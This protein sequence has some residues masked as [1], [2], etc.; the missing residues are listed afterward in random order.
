MSVGNEDMFLRELISDVCRLY[1]IYPYERVGREYINHIDTTRSD[2]IP[3]YQPPRIIF[4]QYMI[5]GVA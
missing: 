1:L 2:G 4:T 5:R 3:V